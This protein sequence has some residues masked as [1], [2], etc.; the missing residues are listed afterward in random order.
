MSLVDKICYYQRNLEKYVDD[1]ER[2]LHCISKLHN[3]PVTVQHLQET[4]VGRTVNSFRKYEGTVGDA[5]RALVF[6]WKTMVADEESSDGEDEDEPCVPDVHKNYPDSQASPKAVDLQENASS[7]QSI[8][9]KYKENKSRHR[10]G[11]SET[12]TKYNTMCSSKSKTEDKHELNNKSKHSSKHHSHSEKKSL[13]IEKESKSSKSNVKKEETHSS[14]K[15]S[16]N[17]TDDSMKKDKINLT[18]RD[19]EDDSR[20]R[21]GDTVNVSKENKKRRLT[22][23]KTDEE[24][25]KL[26]N[27][28]KNFSCSKSSGSNEQSDKQ[29]KQEKSKSSS[30]KLKPE[31][32]NNKTKDSGEKQKFKKDEDKNHKKHDAKKESSHHSK[33]ES[34]KV[35]SSSDKDH[36]KSK[37]KN[38]KSE[39]A[40]NKS[41]RTKIKVKQEINSDDGIDCNSGT[42]FAEALGMCTVSQPLKKRANNSLAQ[43]S[44]KLVKTER[45]SPPIS[46]KKIAVKT[47]PESSDAS[48]P[49]LLAPNIKLE[50]LSADLVTFTLPEISPNYKPLPHVNSISSRREEF[51]PIDD[52]IYVKNQRTKVYSGNKPTA[53]YGAKVPTLYELCL[54]V[55]MD[56]IDALEYTGGVPYDI[57][58]PVLERASAEQLFTL[59]HYNPY[60]IEDT[61]TLWEYHC[62]KEFRSME[63]K[64]MESWR[65]MYMRCLDEREAKLKNVTAN[66]KQSIDNSVPV[67][68]TKLAYV[69]NVVKPPRN[70]LKK[71]A[72]YGTASAIPVTAS[73][74]KKKL[75]SPAA[76]NA[77]NIAV[78]A[79]PM[80]R[81][82]ASTSNNGKK[83]KAPLMAKALQLIKGRYKR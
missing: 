61:D 66:I 77:T 26:L 41:K 11:K 47:E 57:L 1:K 45:L 68:S 82:K 28:D 36:N 53:R 20:K 78:P 29:K 64:E 19:N 38:I 51:K 75:S 10:E 54:R 44:S 74:V 33:K 15:Q 23:V 80:V 13:I 67:R 35:R 56:N 73:S 17:K 3:L 12:T 8:E 6:K 42:S 39:H 5:A 71:Q 62:N 72:K 59:E 30:V 16:H 69:D 24:K 37:E 63:R 50:P 52:I 32:L 65:D 18:V 34:S 22:D 58:K 76:N 2:I 40:E 83:T 9:S 81:F 27:G 49:S 7:D 48:N 70:I 55:L 79:P 43:S 25:S 60:L 46:N 31:E 14:T 21:K 4:G